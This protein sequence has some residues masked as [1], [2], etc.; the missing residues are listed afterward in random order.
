MA[1]SQKDQEPVLGVESVSAVFAHDIS[2][3][4]TTAQMNVELLLEHID[5]L[6]RGL[7][8]PEAEKLP[9]H[10]K[11]ALEKAPQLIRNNL[12]SIQKSISKVLFFR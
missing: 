4:L 11:L 2:T 1:K 5:H 8:S 7:A 10:I 9:V 6:N 3:P 12:D